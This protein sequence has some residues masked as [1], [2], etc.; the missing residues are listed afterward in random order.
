M[1]LWKAFPYVQC[2]NKYTS[3]GYRSWKLA[4][5]NPADGWSAFD[6]NGPITRSQRNMAV[7]Q[8]ALSFIIDL[9][10]LDALLGSSYVVIWF[11]TISTNS[12]LSKKISFPYPLP[13]LNPLQYNEDREMIGH[14][15]VPMDEPSEGV[16]WCC[17]CGG[18]PDDPIHN[19]GYIPWGNV[20]DL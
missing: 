10:E 16:F 19:P 13:P 18:H 6:E 3:M 11:M 4:W 12:K 14:Q 20:S 7:P 1:P 2:V 8:W 17:V 9:L 5:W 15:L